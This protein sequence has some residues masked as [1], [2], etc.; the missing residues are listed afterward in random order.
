MDLESLSLLLS[1][2]DRGSAYSQ[3]MRS[4]GN[5]RL[6]VAALMLL[7]ALPVVVVSLAVYVVIADEQDGARLA[8]A[9]GSLGG[10]FHPVAGGFEPDTTKLADCDTEYR[11]F[12][13]AFG[14]IAYRRGPRVALAL[15]DE[16]IAV[17]DNVAADCHRISHWIGSASFARYDGSVAQTFAHGSTTC[18]SGYYHGVLERAFVGVVSKAQLAGLA[19]SLCVDQGIRRRSFLDR[20]CRHGLGHGLMI[21]TGYDLPTALS[22]CRAQPTAWD[23][24]TCSNGVFMENANTSFGFRSPWLD[25][26]D[27]LYPC[28]RVTTLDRR[29]CIFRAATRIVQLSRYD[30]EEAASTCMRVE[31]PLTRYCFRGLG[32]EAA[33]GRY[34]PATTLE[35]CRLAARW[36]GD[37]LYGA[38]RTVMDRFGS[39]GRQGAVFFCGLAS[40]AVRSQCFSG[41]GGV[42]GLLNP[43]NAARRR[44]CSEVTRRYVDACTS[45]AVAEVDPSGRQSWG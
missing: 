25:D 21:Q 30:F 14:N 29:A 16:H 24:F 19:R 34:V 8:V 6:F 3:H 18:A 15:L 23:H 9:Q 38:A 20:Q 22:L 5:P 12:E 4:R 31:R 7:L 42:L 36:E 26:A 35:R 44:A 28:N 32:R 45:A 10:T 13:Q 33:D 41:I 39:N 27:P 37:C 1:P 17:E 2:Y 43:S 40:S 11:C